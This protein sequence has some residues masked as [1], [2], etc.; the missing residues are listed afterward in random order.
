MTGVPEDAVAVV[1]MALRV[2]GARGPEQFWRDTL[3]GRCFVRRQTDARGDLLWARGRLDDDIALF[4][5]RFFGMSPREALTVDPQHRLLLECAWEAIADAA[6]A[7]P[8]EDAWARRTAVFAGAN[9]SGYRDLL[10]RA[11]PASS[12]LE[13]ETGN[14]KDFLATRIGYRLGLQGPCV[15]V[16]TACSSSLVAV[17]LACQALLEH[18]ADFALAGGVSLVL[19][20]APGWRYEPQGIHSVSGVCRPFD[21]G[22]DGTVMGDGAAMV[23]LQRFEEAVADRRPIYA[24][25]RAS[26]T[27]NDG[28]R[29]I[30]FAAP[31]AAGQ[32][33]VI[34]AAQARAEVTADEI[35]YVE[36]HGTGTPL[37]DCVE[38]QALAEAFSTSTVAPCALGSSK[39]ALGH[40]DAAAGV[41]GLIRASLALHHETI[42][43]TVGHRR[44]AP[45]L[46]LDGTPFRIPVAA[47][48]WI[49][50]QVRRAGVSSFGVGGTNAHIVLEEFRGEAHERG[51]RRT[52]AG[53]G[54]RPSRFWPP[55]PRQGDE[56]AAR[57]V[58]VGF[59]HVV[60]AQASPARPA[61]D[62]PTYDRRVLLAEPGA[63]GQ[64][65]FT[66][67]GA[68]GKGF[69]WA[70]QGPGRQT[71]DQLLHPATGRTLVVS[72]LALSGDRSGTQR[73]YDALASLTALRADPGRTGPCDVVVLTR[74]ACAVL[75]DESGDP[76]QCALTGL[77]RV[78]SAQ[79]PAVRIRVLDLPD[80]K[81]VTLGSAATEA[82]VW[83]D[84]PVL[85][86]R[87]QRWWRQ[88]FP[89]LADPDAALPNSLR[90]AVSVVA[91]IGRI[92]SAAARVL[93]QPGAT[94]VLAARPGAEPQRAEELAR[95]L[96][97][98]AATVLVESCDA[99]N[100][101]EI[102]ALLDRV[103]ARCGPIGQFVLAA[104]IS[105]ERAYQ[106]SSRIPR[107]LDEEQ[108]RVK[109]DGVSALGK[110]ARQHCVKRVVLMSSLAGVLGALDLPAYSAAAAA[111][112]SYA[113]RLDRAGTR[114]LSIGW[115][116]WQQPAANL[117]ARENRMTQDGLTGHEAEQALTRLLLSDVSG[118]LL[119]SKSDFTARWNRFIRHPL[120]H[121][122]DTA[123]AAQSSAPA[124]P[125]TLGTLLNGWRT[126]LNDASLGPDDDLVAHGADSLSAIEVL[127][128]AEARLGAAVPADLFFRVQTVR[129]L[130]EEVCQ[131]REATSRTAPA[132]QAARRRTL[133]AW[134]TTG[135]V[136]WCLH[137][138]SGAADCFAA[139]AGELDGYRVRAVQGAPLAEVS[140]AHTIEGDA[141][142]CQRLLA[143]GPPPAVILGWSYGAV[144]AFEAAHLV[145]RESGRLPTLVALDIP[146]P[147]GPGIRSIGEVPDAEIVAAILS[148]RARHAGRPATADVERLRGDGQ[149]DALAEL[150]RRL[151]ADG[152]VPMGF[153]TELARPLAAGYRRRLTAIEAYRPR[154][155]PGKIVLLRASEPEFG[156]T[157]LLEGVLPAPDRDPSWGWNS[158][159]EHE[160]EVRILQG[161]HTTLLLPP[162]VADV[163]DVVRRTA[164]TDTGE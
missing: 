57:V 102:S 88:D 97:L 28:N 91:G 134:G 63:A 5:P 4:D 106:D 89:Q 108:F 92:G 138:V 140:E 26:A 45:E 107:W 125:D 152:S 64:D 120:R 99:G 77:A 80:T 114:W 95:E 137:P 2:P 109:I 87:G 133:C 65:L 136:V 38:L 129:Q 32:A 55:G 9:Y 126:A 86:R 71:D 151:R 143:E 12:A 49:A 1:G 117:S 124:V 54:Y 62:R 31:S 70:G 94:V 103:V 48:P 58:P 56:P 8:G 52:L 98:R 131:I 147:A 42:P 79:S 73:S 10:L 96:R 50:A 81:P 154:R 11:G 84:E 25:V 150:L 14:D 24:V 3:A 7:A 61:P 105:G 111:M 13:F 82:L 22:A 51:D 149:A 141:A 132:D 60:W 66:R 110:A 67:L 122:M 139:L 123:S 128:A 15:T 104:G 35:G 127:A 23:L 158:L 83:S 30:G 41:V 163:A 164:Q 119:V 156:T 142:A 33:E 68:G 59:H 43:G 113:A 157:R 39:G 34:R 146:A 75:G 155:Y 53:A 116:A 78:L 44:P 153:T 17:H 16:Q 145:H 21:A 121:A 76:A 36:T 6:P 135:P 20:L 160:A 148:D 115:D 130:A 93:A 161:H 18:E 101:V 112:D 40:L 162:R 37:G 27:G 74:Q 159:T 47:E 46:H 69:I 144:L 90:T 85:A 19:P 29:K 72:A 118:H 100:P